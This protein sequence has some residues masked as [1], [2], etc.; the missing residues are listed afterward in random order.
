MNE[1]DREGGVTVKDL[2]GFKSEKEDLR[3]FKSEKEDLRRFK[4]E[5]G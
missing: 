4:S 1:C 5:N 2:R 3:R